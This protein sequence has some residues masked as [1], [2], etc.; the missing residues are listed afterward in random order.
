MEDSTI[1]EWTLAEKESVMKETNE[2]KPGWC[3]L[4]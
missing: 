2:E 1:E 3:Q 4:I